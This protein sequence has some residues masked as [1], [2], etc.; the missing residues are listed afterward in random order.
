MSQLLRRVARSK[1]YTY[2]CQMI[3]DI[4]IHLPKYF[5]EVWICSS[6]G[7]D[8]WRNYDYVLAKISHQRSE[9]LCQA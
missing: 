9:W 5:I 7:P 3:S 4:F 6:K 2:K 8:K 1:K